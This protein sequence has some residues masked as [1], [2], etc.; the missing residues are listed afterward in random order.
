M[1]VAEVLKMLYNITIFYP[2]LQTMDPKPTSGESSTSP[3]SKPPSPTTTLPVR[4]GPTETET[5]SPSSA[6]G[7]GIRSV[8]KQTSPSNASSGSSGAHPS[9]PSKLDAPKRLEQLDSVLVG[10]VILLPFRP[11]APLS[12]SPLGG[13]LLCLGELSATPVWFQDRAVPPQAQINQSSLPT[14]S[15]TPESDVVGTLPPLVAKL[16]QV[17]DRTTAYCFPGDLEPDD[18]ANRA[19]LER[20]GR[21]VVDLD[22]ELAPLLLIIRKCVI[23]DERGQVGATLRGRLLSTRMYVPFSFSLSFYATQCADLSL[24]FGPCRDRSDRLDKRKDLTGRLLRLMAS[25]Y[26]SNTK[27]GAGELLFA[28]C[29]Q[30]CE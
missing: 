16:I 11:Q 13:A 9:S 28:L 26:F 23:S 3:S 15:T 2:R 25:V 6:L 22:A 19:K 1:A 4:S 8:L 5:S 12:G 20:E 21:S 18:A 24:L 27:V 10:L 29:G 14:T 7:R 30:D 17:L